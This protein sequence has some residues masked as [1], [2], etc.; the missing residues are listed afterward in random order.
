MANK[1]SNRVRGNRNLQAHGRT[2]AIFER[3]EDR[4]MFSGGALD[5][6]FGTGGKVIAEKIGFP[7]AAITVQND[8]K[9]IAVGKLAN[10]F[11]IARLN[12]DGKLDQTFGFHGVA[13]AD[14]GGNRGDFATSVAIQPN[15]KIVVGGVRAHASL[16]IF[17]T[18]DNFAVARFNSNGTLDN[19]FDGNGRLTIDFGGVGGGSH[20]RAMAIQPDGRIVVAGDSDTEGTFD[21]ATSRVDFAVARLM[22]NGSLDSSFGQATIINNIRTGTRTIDHL[23]LGDTVTALAVAPDGK[24]VIAGTSDDLVRI[25]RLQPNGSDDGS[26]H[27]GEAILGLNGKPTINAVTAQPDGSVF[28][29]GALDGNFLVTK[30][31]TN[32]Q[33][34]ASF[35]TFG[36]VKA[37][38]GGTDEARS[39]RVSREGVLVAGGSDGKFAMARFS[40]KGLF[41]GFFGAN[42]KVITAVGT[43]EPILATTLTNDGK[44]I[45]YGSKGDAARYISATPKVG[46]FSI[47]NTAHEGVDDASFIVTRDA[48]FDFDTVVYFDLSGSATRGLDYTSTFSVDGRTNMTATS[49]KIS[50]LPATNIVNPVSQRA[51]VKIPAGQSFVVVPVTVINDTISESAE[52]V[53]LT[54]A[55]NTGAN[56]RVDTSNTATVTIAASDLQIIL[57]NPL[58][59]LV[60]LSKTSLAAD[61]FGTQR[62]DALV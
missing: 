58:P 48:I 12:V 41:D 8:G 27:G 20:L 59:I 15:G 39:V 26:F 55:A 7:V 4:Q 45:A 17:G 47:D 42:G 19:S 44:I 35:G 33:T 22:P 34:D 38:F 53:T 31:K 5:P 16:T 57:P 52:T 62:I 32:G 36:V 13:R 51:S 23:N 21:L 9:V 56:Y 24:I 30:L 25:M 61:V 43:N 1:T 50:P 46:I 3:L 49:G 29:V 11:A 2:S 37:D 54:I 28:V 6:T 18:H 14:F 10:D 60:K 40:A